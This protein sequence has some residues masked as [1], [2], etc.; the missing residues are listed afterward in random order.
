[1]V[2]FS[3]FFLRSAVYCLDGRVKSLDAMNRLK[4]ICDLL[5]GALGIDDRYFFKVSVE[6]LVADKASVTAK[7]TWL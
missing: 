5:A 2:E 7:I 3:V 6:K 4:A 1:M